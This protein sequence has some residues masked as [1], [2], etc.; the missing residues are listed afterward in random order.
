MKRSGSFARAPRE[1]IRCAWPSATSM[2]VI[3]LV[4][5][6]PVA[7]AQR[8]ACCAVDAG[9]ELATAVVWRGMEFTRATSVQPWIEASW[10]RAFVEA[11]GSWA[12]DGSWSE[13]DLSAGLALP[14]GGTAGDVALYATAYFFPA[15]GPE[16]AS[17]TVEAV[18]EYTGPPTVP[19]RMLVAR[20]VVNDPDHA[21]YA[22]VGLVP[23]WYG[24]R[25][26]AFAGIALDESA[27]YEAVAGDVLQFGIGL[28]R[29]LQPIS[30]LT[31]SVGA[32][33]IYN[34]MHSRGWVLGRIGIALPLRRGVATAR[35]D[36]PART[37]I[38]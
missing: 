37:R 36:T 7:F 31:L 9:S 4:G 12:F 32:A 24:F 8:P 13:Q 26:D 18:L 23:T 17:P 11:V 22:E 20:N 16:T 25:T 29:E 35:A 27:Y 15:V 19:V 10:G 34:P 5:S 33:A 1:S 21:T 38:N 14:V 3:L 6:L 28:E 2:L 30:T